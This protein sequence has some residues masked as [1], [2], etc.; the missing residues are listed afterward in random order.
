MSGVQLH[1]MPALQHDVIQGGG[2]TLGG[3]HPVSVLN[4]VED[5]GQTTLSRMVAGEELATKSPLGVAM[6][7]AKYSKP[8]DFVSDAFDLFQAV[9][10]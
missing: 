5:L 4:L 8:T 2:A 6:R 3:L 9:W 10:I 1:L 7:F